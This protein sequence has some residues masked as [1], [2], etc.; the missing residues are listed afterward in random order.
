MV[1]KPYFYIVEFFVDVVNH[2]TDCPAECVNNYE[3]NRKDRQ[4]AKGQWKASR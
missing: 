4:V 2:P 1:L 3:D